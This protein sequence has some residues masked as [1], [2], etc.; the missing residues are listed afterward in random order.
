MNIKAQ[1]CGIALL[2]VIMYF[3]ARRRK[4]NLSTE[5]AYK[6]LFIVTFLN[7]FLDV[8]SIIAL[9]YQMYLSDT[10]VRIICKSYISL[11]V[12]TA[13]MGVMYIITDIYKGNKQYLKIIYVMTALVIIGVALVFALPIYSYCDKDQNV[14]TYGPS[15]FATYIIT[16]GIILFTVFL[17]FIKKK[18]MDIR[19]WEAM[20]V[21]MFLWV[22]S[23]VVQFLFNEVL[24]VGFPVPLELLLFILNLRIRR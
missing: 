17:L 21:W 24:L 2:V 13:F 5:R 1:C 22:G 8:I 14:F 3:Y 7:L 10:F 11:I 6:R 19:R 18:D 12:L 23:A 20:R 4:L 16:L 15:V 9:T